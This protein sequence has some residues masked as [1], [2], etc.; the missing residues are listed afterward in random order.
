MM[1]EAVVVFVDVRENSVCR[2]CVYVLYVCV[3]VSQFFC[4]DA[5]EFDFDM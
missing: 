4:E 5:C 1:N 3:S 2:M